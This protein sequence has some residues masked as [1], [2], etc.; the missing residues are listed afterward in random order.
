MT[1]G[2]SIAAV[3]V[4]KTEEE[5]I[6]DFFFSLNFLLQLFVRTLFVLKTWEC[7]ASLDVFDEVIVVGYWG[8][9]RRLWPA[10][11]DLA[12]PVAVSYEW[13]NESNFLTNNKLKP[14]KTL[15]KFIHVLGPET[16]TLETVAVG[17]TTFVT[18]LIIGLAAVLE[19]PAAA[20]FLQK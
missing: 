15:Y 4:Y 20:F 18:L 16:G 13:E 11:I 17:C 5:K 6:L 8:C 9:C 14:Q 2:D 12:K 1:G 19:V 7:P 10:G 3:V